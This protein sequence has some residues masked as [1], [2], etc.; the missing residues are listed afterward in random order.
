MD[1]R[2]GFRVCPPQAQGYLTPGLFSG[3]G[4]LSHCLSDTKGV[5]ELVFSLHFIVWMDPPAANTFSLSACDPLNSLHAPL[6]G[7]FHPESAVCSV[8][9]P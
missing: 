2:E 4:G 6:R 1:V 5:G 8:Q 7:V 9:A 3:P